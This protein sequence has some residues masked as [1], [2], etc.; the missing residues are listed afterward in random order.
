MF[1][2]EFLDP[3]L[4]GSIPLVVGEGRE[5]LWDKTKAAFQYVYDNHMDD[6]EWF[7]KADDDSYVVM[8]NL[9]SML[10]PY[11]TELPIYFGRKFTLPS[12]RPDQGYMSGGAS[13]VLSRKALQKF[14]EDGISVPN[15][16]F[17]GTDH[18]EDLELGRCMATINVV[19]GDSRDSSGRDRFFPLRTTYHLMDH[20]DQNTHWYYNY[21]YYYP[22]EVSVCEKLLLCICFISI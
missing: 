5:H 21:S 18:P 4:P 12:F 8:E 2:F 19:A 15:V 11:P 17:E 9:R 13:Y 20:N 1:R 22:I 7:L 6:A 10:H 16:C 14:I 3:D